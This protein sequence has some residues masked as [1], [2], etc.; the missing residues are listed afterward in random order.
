MWRP[1][2]VS[3]C[4]NQCRRYC[5]ISYYYII[6][7]KCKTLAH[8]FLK[9]VKNAQWVSLHCQYARSLIYI[10]LYNRCCNG[11]PLFLPARSQ[12]LFQGKRNDE[13][14]ALVKVQ[15][16]MFYSLF[17]VLFSLYGCREQWTK[18]EK[19][20]VITDGISI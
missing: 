15:F 11:L 20:I 18:M 16:F 6:F 5:I 19:C 2:V 10:Y 17:H 14:I 8:L 1:L 3:P 13:P 12:S 4:V 7:F 9:Q